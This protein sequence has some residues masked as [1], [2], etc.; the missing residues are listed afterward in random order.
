MKLKITK[1]ITIIALFI[2]FLLA[3][4]TAQAG[5]GPKFEASVSNSH[6]VGQVN[7]GDPLTHEEWVL[8]C[9]AKCDEEY[10]GCEAYPYTCI[11]IRSACYHNCENHDA[12]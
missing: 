4:R 6:A 1:K 5:S 10:E 3:N 12:D 8:L 9:K 2:G 7:L 11:A